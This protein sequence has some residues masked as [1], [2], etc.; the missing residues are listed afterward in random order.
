MCYIQVIKD[1]RMN[2]MLEARSRSAYAVGAT[3]TMPG[4]GAADLDYRIR[5]ILMTV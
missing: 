4:E 5:H 3:E 2:Q 1:D